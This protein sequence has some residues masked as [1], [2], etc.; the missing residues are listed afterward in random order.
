LL[1]EGEVD[2]KSSSS[3]GSLARELPCRI[4]VQ[5]R[6][7]KIKFSACRIS[8]FWVGC[9][10]IR[11]ASSLLLSLNDCGLSLQVIDLRFGLHSHL[12]G[13]VLLPAKKLIVPCLLDAPHKGGD[14]G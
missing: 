14:R 12:L 11:C 9:S 3:L 4:D 10:F 2:S 13:L 6:S 8:R 5:L 7:C 1:L